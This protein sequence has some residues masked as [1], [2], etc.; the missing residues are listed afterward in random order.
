MTDYYATLGV[1][2]NA[3]PDDIKKA[4]RKLASKHHPDKGGTTEQF[5]A[6]QVA[7]DTLSDPDKKA[8]YDN[9][10][11]FHGGGSRRQSHSHHGPFGADDDIQDILREM[12]GGRGFEFNFGGHRRQQR[13]NRSVRL[14]MVVN[15]TD[16]LTEQ[17][18]TIE[19]GLPSGKKELVSV[20]IPAGVR[21]G[22]QVVYRGLG[23][24]THKDLPRGDIIIVL[25]VQNDTKF[26]ID[27]LDLYEAVHV[28]CLE[29]IVGGVTTV[30]TIDG[31]TLELKIPRGSQHGTK[32]SIPSQGLVAK[33]GHGRGRHIVIL[34]LKVPTD[35]TDEQLDVI[36]ST[37]LSK[38]GT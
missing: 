36:R 7:Y 6:I 33:G 26:Q 5:Q 22:E 4:Y 32:L 25:G 2:R 27:G 11:P 37:L 17:K 24:D 35:L 3:T 12:M 38:G 14:E 13:V 18:K 1:D 21:G 20:T 15:L 9:P 10:N 29:A 30:T 31:K 28:N 19:V 8:E 34:D 23:D 16:T